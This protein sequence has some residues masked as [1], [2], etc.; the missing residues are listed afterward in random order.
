MHTHASVYTL[1]GILLT[2][3]WRNT[4]MLIKVTER[5]FSKKNIKKRGKEVQDLDRIL[6][7]MQNIFDKH[8]DAHQGHRERICKKKMYEKREEKKFKS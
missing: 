1:G 7:K 5:E 6:Q 8:F 2:S 3:A 4:L